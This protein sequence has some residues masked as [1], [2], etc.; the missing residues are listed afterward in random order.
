MG[1]TRTP[2]QQRE[3]RPHLP[4]LERTLL[5]WTERSALC[6][7]EK[8]P[9]LPPFLCPSPAFFLVG[10]WSVCSRLAGNVPC[11]GIRASWSSGRVHSMGKGCSGPAGCVVMGKEPG[12]LAAGWKSCRLLVC[13]D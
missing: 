2:E 8:G 6:G 13:G 1:H 10:G 7:L 12:S 3:P 5:A 9:L 11:V 4:H